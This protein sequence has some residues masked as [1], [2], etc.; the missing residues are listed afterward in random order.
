[1]YSWMQCPT[2]QRSYKMKICWSWNP[3]QNRSLSPNHACVQLD[4]DPKIEGVVGKGIRVWE[5]GCDAV[6]MDCLRQ[7]M[8]HQNLQSWH[9]SLKFVEMTNCWIFK[10]SGSGKWNLHQ[11]E[12]IKRGMLRTRS[13]GEWVN[14]KSKIGLPHAVIDW[15]KETPTRFTCNPEHEHLLVANMHPSI[16]CAIPCSITGRTNIQNISRSTRTRNQAILRLSPDDMW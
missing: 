11:E 5:V 14:S 7:V 1:M 13:G 10:R 9:A 12:R 3:P 2:I 4:R 15:L 6:V 16:I 8:V